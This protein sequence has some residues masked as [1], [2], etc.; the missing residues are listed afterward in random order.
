M[1]FR[2]GT[3]PWLLVHE[4]RLWWR[5]L[6]GK[7]FV[8]SLAVLFGMLMALLLFLWVA[9]FSRFVD[10]HQVLSLDPIPEPFFWTLVV[11]WMM[12]FF[13]AFIQ[14]MGQSVVALFDRGDLDLLIASPISS[15]V[16]FASRLLGV[17]LEIFLG[18]FLFIAPVT[19]AT[20][21]AGLLQF[22]GVYPALASLCLVATSLAMLLTLWLVR[23][24]GARRART[25]AQL[26]TALLGAIFFLGSQLPNFLVQTSGRVPQWGR[27]FLAIF[28]ESGFLSADSWIWF[29][30]RTIFLDP[31]SVVATLITSGLLTWLAVEALHRS[32]LNG[33]QQSVT[34]Q[35]RHR[36]PTQPTRFASGLSRVVLFK[37]WRIIGRNPFLISQTLLSVL[38]LIPLLLVVLRGNGGPNSSNLGTVVATAST[39]IGSNLVSVLTLICV[40]GEEAPDLLRSSPAKS[41]DLRR[42]KLLSALIPVWS[43]MLPFFLIL[44]VRREPWLLP[45]AIFLGATVCTSFLRLWN[46]RP[47]SIQAMMQRQKQSALGDP[48]MG[49][50]EVAALFIWGFA[51]FR[52]GQGDWIGTVIALILIG[53]IMGIAYWRSRLLG[54]SLGF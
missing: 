16:I 44:L 1:K 52:S 13:Y 25:V 36:R 42:L 23:L 3:L 11:V 31:P 2:A 48:V 30:V 29:P 22:L 54:T 24:M 19:L 39:F 51:G 41:T 37:E 53:G 5:E 50:L 49:F 18:F 9:V 38:F 47:V 7:W 17:A 27:S 35:Q 14:A 21:L 6:R 45:L 43:L 8:I 12:G 34:I 26:L 28:S 20:T 32:F 10:P 46:A 4:V 33:T 40:S 15:K